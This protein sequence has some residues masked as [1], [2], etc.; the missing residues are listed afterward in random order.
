MNLETLKSTVK[1]LD[2]FNFAPLTANKAEKLTNVAEEN[3]A[4][5][6]FYRVELGP[7]GLIEGSILPERI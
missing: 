1:G 5:P 7:R 6:G 3:F 2:D 4:K